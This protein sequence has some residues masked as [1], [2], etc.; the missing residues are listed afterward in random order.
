MGN[1]DTSGNAE[2]VEIV[3]NYAYVADG[4]GG[5][6]I[7]DISNPAAPTLV[8]NYDTYGNAEDVEIVGNYAYVADGGLLIIDISNRTTP[9]F[10]GN[11]DTYGDAEDVLMEGV[12]WQSSISATQPLLPLWI[13][14]ILLAL[15]MMWK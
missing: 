5:L 11:Y 12:D 13:I 15:L 6:Q 4:G 8:G 2:G 1:Y 9:T 3:G 7:I 10:V 14:I